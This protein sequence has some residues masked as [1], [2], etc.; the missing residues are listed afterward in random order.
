MSVLGDALT[1]EG[2][3]SSP[4]F[5]VQVS[6]FRVNSVWKARSIASI[7]TQIAGFVDDAK[8]K[9]TRSLKIRH[10]G[11]TDLLIR[12]LRKALHA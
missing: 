7:N 10:W 5:K 6:N 1:K 4:H 9:Q 8:R 3:D 12:F 11:F 2:H